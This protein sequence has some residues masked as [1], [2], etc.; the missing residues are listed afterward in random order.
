M[1]ASLQGVLAAHKSD[2]A[3]VV[4]N[5]VGFKVHVPLN[6]ITADIGQE[7]MLLTLMIVRED[8]ITLYGFS[9]E[10]EREAFEKL[11]SVT[12]VGPRI[13]LAILGTMSLDR[14]YSAV[15]GGQADAFSRVPGVGKKIAEKIIFELKSKIKGADGLVPASAGGASD[16]NRDVM[17]ALI[18]FGYSA[19]EANEAIKAIPADVPNDF[20][21][22]MRR[23][24]SY[25]V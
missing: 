6:T 3:V 13:A 17:E 11:I 24:L 7:V 5:G 15:A 2:H 14:L 4:V 25:F 22:R 1:I 16:V 12:G 19:S 23:A 18:S 21:E 20:E 8:A 9:S 10:S